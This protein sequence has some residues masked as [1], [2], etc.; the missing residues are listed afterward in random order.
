MISIDQILI[1]AYIIAILAIGLYEKKTANINVFLFSG[2]KL[3]AP[4][5]IATLV[6][7]WYGGILE[8]G[9]FS[10][11][12]GISTWLVFGLF[13]YIAALI[14]AKFLAEKISASTNDSIPIRFYNS[15]GLIPGIFAVILIFLLASPAPYLKML[16]T[17]FT[18]ILK[19]DI[20]YALILGAF[21]STLYTLKGGFASII[22]TDILQFVLM[23]FG[24]G[25][26]ALYLYLN[27]GGYSFLDSNLPEQMLSFP[28]NLNWT[29]IFTWSFIA[30]ITFIDPSF[31]QRVYSATDKQTAKN[32]IYIS[33]CFWFLFDILS[34]TVGLYSA[35]ILPEVT[36]SPYIDIAELVLPPILKGIFIIS[37]LSIIMST[38][39]SF[40]F[41]S[42]FTIGKDLMLILNKDTSTYKVK[43]GIAISGA[44]SIILASFFTY[45]VDIWYTVGS[46]AVP[47]LLIPL[48]LTYFKIHLKNVIICMLFPIMCTYTWFIYGNQNIDPMYPGIITSIVLCLLN[49]RATS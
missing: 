3:T 23:F 48:I 43:I 35:A 38:V 30:L 18:Y 5:F 47:A 6:S 20:F 7:T 34:I 9:R 29:Y 33:I 16:S 28:G 2:R 15:Y 36:F 40:I 24:F 12:H 11:L 17:I 44:F 46:F 25:Y 45:A 49:K 42:G 1:G 22:K 39:D 10:N 37:I 19:I 21:I 4:A 26:M 14:Y 31:Y 13:Y 27:Y 41:I 8:I 32:G